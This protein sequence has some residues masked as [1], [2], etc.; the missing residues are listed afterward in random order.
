M[1]V[2][3][4]V[5][6]AW[7]W[8]GTC[9]VLV[10]AISLLDYYSGPDLTVSLFYFAV[11]VLYSW[12]TGD[13]RQ[14]IIGA[15]GISI[16]WLA[17]DHFTPGGPSGAVL[18]WNA[19]MRLIML[20]G[21]AV[22]I[23]RLRETLA[24]EQS[25]ARSDFLTDTLNGRAFAERAELEIARMRRFGKP[26]TVAYA[27]VDDFKAINDRY[28]HAYGDHVLRSVA[29]TLK[30]SLRDTDCL[31]RVGGDEFVMLLPETDADQAQSVLSKL[32]SVVSESLAAAEPGISVSI[33]AVV[34]YEPPPAVDD[35]T[36][37]SDA[38]MY[39]AKSDG[40]NRVCIHAFGSESA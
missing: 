29:R 2:P 7:P 9:S 10:L 32:H 27:D 14:S 34:F 30:A 36:R 39:S 8:L 11:I 22:I 13:L 21:L 1:H 16:V 18:A 28:G 17:A 31:S 24:S 15:I 37:A 6:F 23:C 38:A 35:L 26:L 40:K 20:V 5:P 12:K 33:G 25:L 19:I 4:R 3:R